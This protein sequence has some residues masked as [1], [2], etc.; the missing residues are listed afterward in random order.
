MSNLENT[1]NDDEFFAD[2]VNTPKEGVEQHRKRKCL[3]TRINR[4]MYLLVGKKPTTRVRI[5]KARTKLLIKHVLNTSSE[6]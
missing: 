6:K 5:D 3:K 2:T 1:L 4:Y